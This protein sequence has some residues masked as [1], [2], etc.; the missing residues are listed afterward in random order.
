[1]L[2]SYLSPS[3]TK[4]WSI[5]EGDKPLATLLRQRMNNQSI[6]LTYALKVAK[7]KWELFAKEHVL[8]SMNPSIQMQHIKYPIIE[9]HCKTRPSPTSVEQAR[10]VVPHFSIKWNSPLNVFRKYNKGP[11]NTLSTQANYHMFGRALNSPPLNA[12]CKM[13]IKRACKGM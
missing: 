2:I 5:K 4:W 11:L 10:L 13:S 9:E 6:R 8:P 3:K 12:K 1:M 7:S